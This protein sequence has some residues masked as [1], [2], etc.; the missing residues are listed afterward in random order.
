MI[1]NK[2]R[3]SLKLLTAYTLLMS[4]FSSTSWS[5]ED[6]LDIEEGSYT[7]KNRGLSIGLLSWTNN[8]SRS[9]QYAQV[10]QRGYYDE[11]KEKYLPGGEYRDHILWDIKKAP[12]G[13]YTIKN[14]GLSIGLLS[15]TYEKSRSGQYAQVL[16]GGYYDEDK[17]KYLP[18]GE[19]RDHILWE[20]KP[21]SVIKKIARIDGGTIRLNKNSAGQGNLPKLVDHAAKGRE[22]AAS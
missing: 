4:I 17:D 11:E 5:M 13:G 9:G 6:N 10:L 3:A 21:V 2:T 12:E 18:G 22:E 8:K 1:K 15:W 14:R 20:I 16:Q 7:I 19:Y